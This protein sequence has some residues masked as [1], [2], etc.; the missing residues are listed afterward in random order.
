[1]F[2]GRGAGELPTASAVVGD[3]FEIVRNIQA[4]CCAR[5]GCTCYKELPVKKM[6]DTCNRYFMRLIVEDRCGVLAEMTAVFAK[7][8]VSVAQ[9]IQKAARDEGSAEVVVI[10]AKVRE[11]DFRTA[12]EELSGRTSVRKISSMLRVYGE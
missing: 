6:A 5:I 8:G 2:Y 1:M 9:I 11:G 10:T 3:L 4:N 7:Y 12:M